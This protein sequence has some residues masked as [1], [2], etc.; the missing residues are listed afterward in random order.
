MSQRLISL[1]PALKR[2]RDEGYD[3]SIAG[4]YL[5][6]GHVPYVTDQRQVAYG[7]L[8][9]PVSV[10]GD[11]VLPPSDHTMRFVGEQPCTS[12]GARYEKIIN[13]MVN[14]TVA[15][16]VVATYS[17]S[18]KPSTGQYVDYYEKMTTYVAILGTEAHA[19]DAT[20]TARAFLPVA[21]DGTEGSVFHYIDT[22]SSRAGINAAN[23][24]LR[25][26]RVAI[27]GLGGTG[28]HILDLVAKTWV[29]QIH[30]Y[31][32]DLL[33]QHNAFRMPGALSEQDLKTAGSKVAFLSATYSKLRPGIVPHECRV[34]EHNVQELTEMDFVFLALTDGAAKKIIIDA[35]EQHE[36]PFIDCG[37]GLYRVDDAL[38]GQVRI[39]TSTPGHR[40]EA[41]RRISFTDG[42]VDEYSQNIQIA[43]LNSLNANLAVLKWKKLNGFYLDLDREHNTVFVLDGNTMINEDWYRDADRD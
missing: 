18:C 28:S 33:Q 24:K 14:E 26:Q 27:V 10:S 35:L 34:D 40:E 41:R 13:Q 11:V 5:V 9:C 2:L 7:S 15:P 22:A 19:L 23:E 29:E 12:D 16:G 25:G 17:F 30:L 31:D 36:V 4:G 3:V 20:A 38:A 42:E 8:A 43:E 37:M 21:N 6:V 39:T 32:D 1:D